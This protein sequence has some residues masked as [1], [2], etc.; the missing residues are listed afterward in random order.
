MAIVPGAF[1]DCVG[2]WVQVLDDA[3]EHLRKIGYSVDVVATGGRAD[4]AA[5]A[6][7]IAAHVRRHHQLRPEHRLVFVAYS[8]GTVDA[9][10]AL[11]RHADIASRV[12]ALVS[13]AG[14]INGT[15]VA[16]SLASPLRRLVDRFGFSE[17]AR[18]DGE[19]V[20]QAQRMPRM[21]WLA[22]RTSP[23]P[24]PVYSI[25][26]LPN[27]D[28]VSPLLASWHMQLSRISRRNDGVMF[29]HDAIV[30]HSTLLAYA[31][32]DHFSIAL[33]WERRS[34]RLH[35]WFV[36]TLPFPRA[37]LVEAALLT[38]LHANPR[39]PERRP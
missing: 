13:I 33:P 7:V 12:T 19:F 34:P 39:D 23:P 30:A 27:P 35:A 6:D 4:V 22:R 36:Q 15:A 2:D 16:E 1:H 24:V 21:S 28:R 26:A 37:Q 14:M 10:A 32:A 5:N 9:L 29:D 17:C 25:V 3:A 20:A 38:A 11:E 31:N 18:A 8:K